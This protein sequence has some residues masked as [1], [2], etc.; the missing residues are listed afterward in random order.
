MYHAKLLADIARIEVLA[1]KDPARLPELS[2][3]LWDLAVEASDQDYELTFR[4]HAERAMQVLEQAAAQLEGPLPAASALEWAIEVA[5]RAGRWDEAEDLVDRIGRRT[6]DREELGAWVPVY[7]GEC[8]VEAAIEAARKAVDEV[9][10]DLT[11]WHNAQRLADLGAWLAHRGDVAGVPAVRHAVAAIRETN[12]PDPA[13]SAIALRTLAAAL[14]DAGD[15]A[16]AKAAAA[17]AASVEPERT[18]DRAA[19]PFWYCPLSGF[20]VEQ[21]EGLGASYELVPW[22]RPVDA[23]LWGVHFPKSARYRTRGRVSG[24]CRGLDLSIRGEV[25]ESLSHGRPAQLLGT[26]NDDTLLL[27]VATDEDSPSPSVAL[28]DHDGTDTP[29]WIGLDTLLYDLIREA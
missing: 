12:V 26:S 28:V 25:E 10:Y 14:A 23:L 5:G 18:P 2:N 11:V 27:I 7:L 16:G 19:P 24:I 29:Q 15:L 20:I 1:A 8:S 6:P 13:R 21:L 9:D 17:E 4:Q 22:T 3:C